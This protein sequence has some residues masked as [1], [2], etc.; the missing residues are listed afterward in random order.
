M[1]KLSIR[2]FITSGFILFSCLFLPAAQ[3]CDKPV[4]PYEH[5]EFIWPYIFG[6]TCFLTSLTY[7]VKSSDT[8]SENFYKFFVKVHLLVYA[9]GASVYGAFLN[10]T[11]LSAINQVYFSTAESQKKFTNTDLPEMLSAT[12]FWWFILFASFIK[13]KST[14]RLFRSN[15]KEPKINPVLIISYWSG[16]LLSFSFFLFF[17]FERHYYGIDLSLIAS[18]TI[19][20]T[21]FIE[22]RKLTNRLFLVN[23]R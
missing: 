21:A 14:N 19:S 1:N 17:F 10:Y 4:Y 11:S 16:A 13:L 8:I 3:G 12:I 18:A 2:F 6:F 5:L 23:L 15:S 22:Q 9:V 20:T 7:A